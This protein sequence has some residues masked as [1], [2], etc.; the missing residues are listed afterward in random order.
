MSVMK[1]ASKFSTLTMPR[2]AKIERCVLS[3]FINLMSVKIRTM[4]VSL[5]KTVE[6]LAAALY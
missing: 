4:K 2:K 1:S 6:L 5:T 3:C